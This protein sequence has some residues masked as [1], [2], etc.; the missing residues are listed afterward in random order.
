MIAHF[1]FDEKDAKKDETNK[2]V[3]KLFITI[4]ESYEQLI[5]N[6]EDSSHLDRDSKDLEDQVC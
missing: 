5:Q 2:K 3:Y 6:I 4:N 1:F